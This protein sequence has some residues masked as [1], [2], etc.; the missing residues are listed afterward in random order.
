[1][2][3]VAI[4]TL[5]LRNVFIKNFLIEYGFH[6]KLN[7][8]FVFSKLI[9]RL[10]IYHH[11]GSWTTK[12]QHKWETFSGITL[13]LI[14]M[15]MFSNLT[16]WIGF[17]LNNPFEP[18]KLFFEVSVN[19]GTL[20]KTVDI[21]ILFLWNLLIKNVWIYLWFLFETKIVIF[22]SKTNKKHY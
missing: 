13:Q 6:L 17:N 8:H 18:I 14:K 5:F 1:M 10:L 16:N 3:T 22:S 9:K 20:L 4:W 19:K 15:E 12:M 7:Y 11:R 21:A 2:K